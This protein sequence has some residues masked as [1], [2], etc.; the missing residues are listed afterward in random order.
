M[1]IICTQENLKKGLSLVSYLTKGS[2]TLPILNNV[3]LK[4]ETGFLSLSTTNLEIGITARVRCKIE[5]EGEF[6]VSAR[7]LNDFVSFLPK[8]NITLEKTVGGLQVT[9]QNFTTTIKGLEATDFPIIPKVESPETDTFKLEDFRKTLSK[10]LFSVAIDESRP[11]ISGVLFY[12]RGNSL[13]LAG[14]DSYRLS[15]NSI[16]SILNTERKVII[17]LRTLQEVMRMS[18]ESQAQDLRLSLA[19]SQVTFAYG[20]EAE[21]VSRLI[22]GAFPDYQQVIPTNFNLEAKGNV[23]DFSQIVKSVA[24]FCKPGINDIKLTF[25]QSEQKITVETTNN[26]LGES[27]VTLAATITG[28]DQTVVFNYRYLLDGLQAISSDE[29]LFKIVDSVS[30]SLLSDSKDQGFLYVIMPI[31]Q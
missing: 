20:E 24:L 5:E 6:T 4:T 3:L 23:R 30:P 11:E 2:T 17:P 26:S 8:E 13:I 19:E 28:T 14:T 7:L 1:K 15:E 16:N 18:V 9:C 22:E 21:L 31:R 10:V 27:K 25:S 12:K 29:F